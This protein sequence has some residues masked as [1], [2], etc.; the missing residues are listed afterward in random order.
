M[1]QEGVNASPFSD[2]GSVTY[3]LRN[4]NAIRQLFYD[5]TPKSAIRNPQL[6]S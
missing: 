2:Q 5:V 1:G 6:M 4:L 3:D